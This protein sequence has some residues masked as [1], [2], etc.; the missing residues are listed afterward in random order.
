MAIT[1]FDYAAVLRRADAVEDAAD[2]LDT[3][4]RRTLAD[5]TDT[6]RTAWAGEAA[7]RFFQT[8]G[9][10]GEALGEQSAAL[11]DLADR[12]RRAARAIEE[13]ERLAAQQV[14]TNQIRN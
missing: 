13:A 10:Q 8:C 9:A 7:D 12:I 5:I 4:R 11:R 1:H 2:Q 3:L 14:S 6:L